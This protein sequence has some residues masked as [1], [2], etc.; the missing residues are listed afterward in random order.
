MDSPT[1]TA[2]REKH[3]SDCFVPLNN[4]ETSVGLG[5]PPTHFHCPSRWEKRE[6]SFQLG[7]AAGETASSSGN[8]GTARFRLTCTPP[9]TSIHLRLILQDTHFLVLLGH[10]RTPWPKCDDWKSK[11]E[12]FPN[13][14]TAATTRTMTG[15][16]TRPKHT[17]REHGPSLS[18]LPTNR[19]EPRA[20]RFGVHPD[21]NLQPQMRNKL[22]QYQHSVRVFRD[23]T[24]KKAVRMHWGY[25]TSHSQ[26]VRKMTTT[27]NIALRNWVST[28]ESGMAP[29]SLLAQEAK[30]A[31]LADDAFTV[32]GSEER[33]F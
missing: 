12:P 28:R 20:V 4:D 9:P 21:R 6:I 16:S 1:F 19:R 31:G 33:Q 10:R 22:I 30:K 17:R 18:S 26:G 2:L 13:T 5:I 23:L 14:A 25:V 24:A 27:T 11:S 3:N 32:C 7:A 29:P 8:R 15:L